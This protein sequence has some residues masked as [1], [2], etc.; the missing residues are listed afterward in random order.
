MCGSSDMFHVSSTRD[1]PS[2]SLA[3]VRLH[4]TRSRGMYKLKSLALA[5]GDSILAVFTVR[6]T[7]DIS[8]TGLDGFD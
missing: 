2:L 1:V 5:L 6:G 4:S 7:A 3:C 8:E